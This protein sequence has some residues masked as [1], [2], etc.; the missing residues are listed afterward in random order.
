MVTQ[1][2]PADGRVLSFGPVKT[3]KVEQVKGIT[4]SLQGFLGEPTWGNRLLHTSTDHVNHDAGMMM[5]CSYNRSVTYSRINVY[6]ELLWCLFAICL[7]I[8]VIFVLEDYMSLTYSLCQ[9]TGIDNLNLYG[10]G[11][12]YT[13]N[14]AASFHCYV[15]NR[16]STFFCFEH[17]IFVFSMCNKNKTF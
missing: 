6:W 11:L 10:N 5:L 3:C 1:V 9:N 14:Y 15:R 17:T 2:S 12:V 7:A 13:V 4:Y 8:R 16:L